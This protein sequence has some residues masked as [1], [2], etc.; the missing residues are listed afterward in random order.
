[1]PTGRILIVE[2]RDSLRRM[3]E[4]ALSQE[5][6]EVTAAADA[7]AGIR[8]VDERPFDL[9]LTDLKL[10]DVSGLEVL[11]ASRRAQPRVPVVVL[12][13]FGTVGAAVEAMKL[14]AYD[15]LEKP[16]EIDDLARLI[17]RAIGERDES[18]VF[19]V[20]GA[21]AIVGRHPRL[22]AAIRL[23]QR[24]AATESTV[25]LTG[26]SGTGKE[27]FSRALHALSPRKEGPFVAL[28]CAAIPESLLE[29][30]LF[31]HEKGAF[32]GA[33]RRQPGRFEMADR[34][35]LMLDEIGELPLS[36]QGKVLRVLEERTYER[37]GG[38]RTLRADVRLV[39]ATNRDLD[40]MVS[41]G[42][43]RS[44]LFFRLNVF[45]IELPCL[46]ERA[47]DIPLLARHLLGEIARRHKLEPPRL[48]E[49]AEQILMDQPWPGN[50]RELANILERAVI[51][52]DGPAL[53][54]SD[55]R[56]L[57][58]LLSPSGE[59]DRVRQA[60]VDTGGDKKKAADLLGMSYRT[61]QRKVKEYDLEGVPRYRE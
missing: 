44:D 25:L 33:D 55:L 2:D 48:E 38:G 29:N 20:P 50:V 57:L 31:G 27:M 24:V 54:A 52:S 36:V 30:E 12:T 18:V 61:L 34:G 11:A 6:Y 21:P 13:G 42:A 8:W 60:L 23:L 4:R 49:D 51:L 10:P 39:A 15:F 45:P 35:T 1:M 53:R 22:R 40:S 46:R 56:P 43:F 3:L 9:V 59:R 28:N 41:E 5:G 19:H 58:H 37:V 7:Q 16:L 47:S 26:E 14:G 32:T 17:E